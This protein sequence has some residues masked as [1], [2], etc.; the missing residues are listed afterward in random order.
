LATKKSAAAT[1]AATTAV[2]SLICTG[3]ALVHWQADVR[4]GTCCCKC[5]SAACRRQGGDDLSATAGP[6]CG[7]SNSSSGR[8]P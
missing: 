1:R 5:Y 6:V 2:T 7:C 3:A 4:L 8:R